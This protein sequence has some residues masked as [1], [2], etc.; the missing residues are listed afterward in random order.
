M[1][2][3]S[4][5][6]YVSA[7][8]QVSDALTVAE[9]S[10]SAVLSCSICVLPQHW[11]GRHRRNRHTVCESSFLFAAAHR[12]ARG[13]RLA[14]FLALFEEYL[15]NVAEWSLRVYAGVGMGEVQAGV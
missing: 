4:P 6:P 11:V 13:L 15:R 2:Q 1:Y 8:H 3:V 5:T 7:M 14:H 9:G 12:E 10:G